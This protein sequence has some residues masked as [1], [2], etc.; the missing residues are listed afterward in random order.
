MKKGTIKIAA[1]QVLAIMAATSVVSLTANALSPAGLS[2]QRALTLRE[3]DARFLTLEE[4]KARF[5]AGQSI[6]LDA[7][8]SDQFERGRIAGALS[9]PADQFDNR[10]LE[11]ATALPR[12][13]E[14]VIYCDGRSC[15][16]GH[17][18]ADKL[19]AAGYS[20]IRIFRDG[21]PGWKAQGWPTEP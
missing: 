3:L 2:I 10:F 1:V 21:W 15:A 11:L 16:L 19:A 7:R 6:F 4:A 18:V 20:Q 13:V 17:Q 14:L 5:D 9:L 8:R 12:E